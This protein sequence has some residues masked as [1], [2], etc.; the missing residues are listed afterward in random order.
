M[1][2]IKT[3]E[4]YVNESKV[5]ENLE[6]ME[7]ARGLLAYDNLAMIFNIGSEVAIIGGAI[8]GGYLLGWL[9]NIRDDRKRKEIEDTVK[10]V[11]YKLEKSSKFKKL[12]NE[13]RDVPYI[14]D[15]GNDKEHSQNVDRLELLKSLMKELKSILNDKELKFFKEIK[16]YIRKKDFEQVIGESCKY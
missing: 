9:K 4:Q 1:K 16:E 14:K 13:I 8:A 6:W 7:L 5:N 12:I 11:S 10:E 3:F 2:Y 15:P